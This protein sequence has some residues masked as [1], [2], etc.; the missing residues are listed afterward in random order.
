MLFRSEIAEYLL[1]TDSAHLKEALDLRAASP[2]FVRIYEAGT[3][4]EAAALAQGRCR[5]F[6]APQ[7][8]RGSGRRCAPCFSTA[9]GNRY[10]GLLVNTIAILSI[11]NYLHKFDGLVL[12][13]HS[14]SKGFYDALD[15]AYF[16]KN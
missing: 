1:V 14:G 13:P 6:P 11:F 2:D 10:Y 16:L 5:S 3:P 8:R 15:K 7:S 12:Y 9:S 4:D